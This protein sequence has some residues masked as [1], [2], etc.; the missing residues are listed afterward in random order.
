[1]TEARI[2]T[3]CKRDYYSTLGIKL[4]NRGCARD[5]EKTPQEL[6]N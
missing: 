2:K 1:M 5:W 6:N 4:K 3:V